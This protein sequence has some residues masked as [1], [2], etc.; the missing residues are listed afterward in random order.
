MAVALRWALVACLRSIGLVSAIFGISFGAITSA[1]AEPSSALCE[2]GFLG[3]LPVLQELA[4]LNVAAVQALAE[5]RPEFALTLYQAF[6]KSSAQAKADGVDLYG[7]KTMIDELSAKAKVKTV[8]EESRK[9]RV[10]EAEELRLIDG[11]RMMFHVVAP[12]KFVMG[13]MGQQVETE[14]TKPFGMAA[15]QTTQLVWKKVIDR[16]KTKFPGKYDVLNIESSYFKGDLNPV[17]RVSYD[18]VHLWLNA[19]NDLAAVG[20][21]V[22]SEVMPGHK[23][24]DIYRLP[25]E[26]EW[27]FVARARGADRGAHHFGENKA[28]LDDHAWHSENAGE[29]THPVA[30][31]TPLWIDERNFYDLYGNVWEWVQDR[32]DSALKGGKDPQGP[33]AG[34]VH[35]VARGGGWNDF[36]HD[37]RAGGRNYWRPNE[38]RNVIGFRLVRASSSP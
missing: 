31:K 1:H 11:S 36:A 16:A 32:Y 17:E 6:R 14:I 28:E 29:Q 13:E 34:R 24:G 3:S 8:E 22:V 38:R 18:D 35:R 2:A 10:H 30:Q 25:T 33:S 5:G 9:A 37:L 27:E 15:T 12:G 19:L 23:Q 7:L 21:S 26:A 20:D 4:H